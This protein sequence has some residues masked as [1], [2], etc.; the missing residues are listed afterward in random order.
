MASGRQ[1]A[2]GRKYGGACLF[3]AEFRGHFI[4]FFISA[5]FIN[6]NDRAGH[7]PNGRKYFPPYNRR[8][9]SQLLGSVCF[10]VDPLPG[11]C[12]LLSDCVI[13]AGV[14]GFIPCIDLLSAEITYEGMIFNDF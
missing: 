4:I 3:A 5:A 8:T 2:S 7:G 13:E 6:R 11:S 9:R 12:A 1:H 14:F 10:G